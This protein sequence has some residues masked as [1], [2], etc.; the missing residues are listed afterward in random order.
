[1]AGDGPGRG[2][3]VT[4]DAAR[5][6]AVELER[7]GLAAPARLLADA[8]RPL[9]PLLSDIGVALGGLVTAVGGP[10]AVR[11]RELI[12]DEASLDRVL[13]RLDEA[14]GRRAEPG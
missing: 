8:H 9:G 13:E 3:R 1:M 14:G 2:T 5:R 6:I 12:E 7:R 11:L 4:D 10:S